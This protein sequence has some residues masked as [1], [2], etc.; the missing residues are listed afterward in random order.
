MVWPVFVQ[1]GLLTD[2]GYVGQTIT[3]S[4]GM[5]LNNGA[6]TDQWICADGRLRVNQMRKYHGICGMGTADD[7]TVTAVF[8]TWVQ[9]VDATACTLGACGLK[10]PTALL[11]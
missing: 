11:A 2:G 6:G 9:V 3:G 7:I 10:L 8:I 1:V 5:G 4:G